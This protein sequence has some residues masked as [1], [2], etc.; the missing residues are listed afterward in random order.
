MVLSRQWL[1][2]TIFLSSYRISKELLLKSLIL[3]FVYSTIMQTCR[4]QLAT[5]MYGVIHKS[6]GQIFLPTPF[7]KTLQKRL[8]VAMW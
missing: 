4:D 1:S 3:T 8:I 2:Q 7:L 6:R 5:T